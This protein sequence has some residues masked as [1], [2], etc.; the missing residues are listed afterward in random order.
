MT[1]TETPREDPFSLGRGT[2]G[3]LLAHATLAHTGRG[4]WEQAHVWAKAMVASPVPAGDRAGLFEGA[5]A[6]AFALYVADHPAYA[7][8]L[9]TVHQATLD[10]IARRLNDAEARMRAGALPELR[11]YDL[12]S[13]LTGLGVYLLTVCPDHRLL[14][15]VL[16]YLV[17]L[18]QPVDTAH[19]PVPGW[20]T[21]NAPTDHPDPVFPHGHGNLGLAHGVSGPLA[22]LAT[23]HLAG[24]IVPDHQQALGRIL[25]WLDTWNQCPQRPWWPEWVITPSPTAGDRPQRGRPSWCYGAPGIAWAHHLAGRT[26]GDQGRQIQA[27][28]ALLTATEP[29]QVERLTGPGLCHGHA[30]LQL[31]LGRSAEHALLPEL[32]N[33]APLPSPTAAAPSPGLL[34]GQ[35]GIDLARTG[36]TTWANCLLLG[37]TPVSQRTSTPTS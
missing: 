1:T 25:T 14:T 34:D 19:G 4:S 18:T 16:S 30:G 3:I 27:E 2:P 8:A 22:L 31:I 26:L 33:L 12:I 21:P 24:I 6:V 11:E 13:G 28:R 29:T 5:P 20:W 32:R 10:L 23:T 17:R 37:P 36:P 15:E 35:A 7:P 9:D